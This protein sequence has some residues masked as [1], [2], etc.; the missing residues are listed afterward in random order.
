MKLFQFISEMLGIRN[1]STVMMW[2]GEWVPPVERGGEKDMKKGLNIELSLDTDILT[3]K[4]EAIARHAEA[5]A[6][7]LKQIDADKCEECGGILNITRLYG[8]SEVVEELRECPR[9]NQHD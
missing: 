5:L 1:P 2:V 8:D 7:E 4:L 6:D 9:C 3:L